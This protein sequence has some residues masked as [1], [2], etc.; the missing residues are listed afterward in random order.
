MSVKVLQHKTEIQEARNELLRRGVS[1]MTGGRLIDRIFNRLRLKKVL[2]VGNILKSWDVLST[3]DFIQGH[4]PADAPILDIG[5][6]FS[7]IIGVLHRM[8]CTALAGIDLNP[9]VVRMPD[10]K[11]IRYEVGNFMHTPFADKTFA[12]ITAVS[13]IEHGFQSGAL[14]KEISRLL[15]P[16][17]YFIASFD[18]WPE[19]IDTTGCQMF[20]TDWRIFSREEVLTFI[21]EAK[22]YGLSPCGPVDLG[23]AEALIETSGKNYTF[24]WIALQ[25]GV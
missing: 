3:A 24:G 4:L 8:K 5:A 25:K 22:G 13:V 2:P 12:A 9:D 11:K 6:C 16:G 15:R 10:A 7:E 14:L 17:G 21:E 19:K 20:N 23:A 1:A 18:Y